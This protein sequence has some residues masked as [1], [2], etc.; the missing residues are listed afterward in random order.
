MLTFMGFDIP[1]DGYGYGTRKIAAE[2]RRIDSAVNFV[3]MTRNGRLTAPQMRLWT[4]TGRAVALC[5][6]DWFPDVMCD[7][8]IGYT[9]FEATQLP[10]GWA[11]KINSFCARLLVPCEWTRQVFEASGVT[12]PIELA[13]W[14]MEAEDYWYIDREAERVHHG[15]EDRPYTFFWSGTPDLRKGWDVAYKA[16]R[17]AFGDRSDVQL[18]MHFREALPGDPRFADRN[19]RTIVGRVDTYKWRELLAGVDAFVF[20]SRGEGWGLPP[21]EA[22]AT[23][24]PTIATDYGGLHEDLALWGLPLNVAGFSPAQFGEWNA[25][26]VGE[27]AEPDVDHLVTLLRWCEANRNEAARRGCAS[28]EWLLNETPWSRTARAVL[29]GVKNAE[30]KKAVAYAG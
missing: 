2:L 27:W 30:D 22:A 28:S 7:E 18:L 15:G 14:G 4:V 8:L 24:L 26:D 6:P 21:R 13:P 19:V 12:V 1:R 17:L 5:Q 29:R 9:M 20:P 11:D 16:F 25:G 23:G 10:R 3:D